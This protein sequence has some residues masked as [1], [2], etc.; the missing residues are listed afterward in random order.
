MR[1]VS[2][3]LV[4]GLSS[5]SILLYQFL[6]PAIGG[7]GRFLKLSY[8]SWG[9][10]SAALKGILWDLASM[11]SR[12]SETPT[13]PRKYDVAWSST[14]IKVSAARAYQ[15]QRG[16]NG[17]IEVEFEKGNSECTWKGRDLP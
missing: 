11:N 15:E 8:H 2:Q 1:R 5:S 17:K 3:L 16:Q 9:F 13:G 6:Q 10:D 7:K 14:G 4:L 12:G